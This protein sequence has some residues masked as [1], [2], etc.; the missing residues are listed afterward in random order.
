MA[1]F[2][3]SLQGATVSVLSIIKHRW[4]TGKTV[5]IGHSCAAVTHH[6]S[7]TPGIVRRKSLVTQVVK[8]AGE[9]AAGV[10]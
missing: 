4:E 5:K 6:K 9:E 8:K 10:N 3:K 2:G 7:P 1:W